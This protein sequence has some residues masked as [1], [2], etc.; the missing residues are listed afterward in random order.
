MMETQFTSGELV[1]HAVRVETCVL[2]DLP[3]PFGSA[4][5]LGEPC[6]CLGNLILP[7]CAGL[8][9]CGPAGPFLFDCSKLC[10]LTVDSTLEA[11]LKAVDLLS[12]GLG[13]E[14]QFGVALQRKLFGA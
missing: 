3:H 5:E 1:K 7:G 12:L 9:T 10:G 13:M 14:R 2:G 6:F 8:F 11:G 4:F